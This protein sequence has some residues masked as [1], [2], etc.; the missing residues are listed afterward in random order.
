[1]LVRKKSK[2]EIMRKILTG[3]FLMASLMGATFMVF[4]GGTGPSGD[5]STVFIGTTLFTLTSGLLLWAGE[6]SKNLYR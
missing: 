6:V 2:R 1:M 4:A 3:K 5:L